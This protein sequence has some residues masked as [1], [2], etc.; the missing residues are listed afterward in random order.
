MRFCDDSDEHAA[1]LI[2]ITSWTFQSCSTYILYH[3]IR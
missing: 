2:N 1:L 3:R